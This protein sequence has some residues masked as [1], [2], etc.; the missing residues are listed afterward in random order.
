MRILL[1]VSTN[2]GSE[3]W[4]NDCSSELCNW[5]MKQGH[6]NSV[7]SSSKV[8]L[9]W[10]K[11]H[12]LH[13][14]S[15]DERERQVEQVV[16]HRGYAKDAIRI[17]CENGE[18]VPIKMVPREKYQHEMHREEDSNFK[19]GVVIS[20]ISCKNP[21]PR[22]PLHV[23]VKI[24]ALHRKRCPGEADVAQQNDENVARLQHECHS[25]SGPL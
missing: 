13:L 7:N 6:A 1:F 2:P 17:L 5:V 3:K 19:L 9:L 22:P 21:K 16:L 11:R 8:E 4:H 12:V 23:K 24:E 20:Q 15:S 25:V 14:P 18:R 10:R